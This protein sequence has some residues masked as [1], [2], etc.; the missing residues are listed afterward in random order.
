MLARPVGIFFLS[1][2][3]LVGAIA[4]ARPFLILPSNR[5]DPGCLFGV[6]EP[7][8]WIPLVLGQLAM[9]VAVAAL[10][11]V[12]RREDG[13]ETAGT[14][15]LLFVA[16]PL[17]LVLALDA[18][19]AASTALSLLALLLAPRKIWAAGL[20]LALAAVLTPAAALM[21]PAVV[22]AAWSADVRGMRVS[23]VLGA[24]PAA[25]VLVVGAVRG[26]VFAPLFSAPW[27][28]VQSLTLAPGS[29][30]AAIHVVAIV[31]TIAI[32]VIAF[33]RLRFVEGFAGT[34]WIAVG[35]VLGGPMA[36]HLGA[37]AV[38]PWGAAAGLT[39]KWQ[40]EGPLVGALFMI[41][42]LWLFHLVHGF[43][44]A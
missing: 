15:A 41:Q 33:A 22:I 6:C 20:V 7:Y 21:A 3:A 37:G 1:R 35:L 40:L 4:V 11:F 12:V 30:L 42:G 32:C 14:A 17:S 5:Q 9:A 39:R 26:A 38:A 27:L 18:S 25:I 28:Q 2:V 24:L 19:V 10:W 13:I 43:R 29:R 36:A 34:P 44:I 8:G 23:A 16:S 31:V